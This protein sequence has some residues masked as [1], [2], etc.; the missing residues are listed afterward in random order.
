MALKRNPWRISRIHGPHS[1]KTGQ[2]AQPALLEV[3]NFIFGLALGNFWNL[4]FRLMATFGKDWELLGTM[5]L[6]F[7]DFLE[8][9]SWGLEVGFGGFWQ[10]LP[11]NFWSCGNFWEGCGM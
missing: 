3:G 9:F 4:T 7:P 11:S 6:N 8:T 5:L 2:T 1:Q 10:L